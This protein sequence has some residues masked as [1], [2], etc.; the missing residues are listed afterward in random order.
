MKE[1]FPEKEIFAA[2]IPKLE[3]LEQNQVPHDDVN[4]LQF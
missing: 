4:H 2:R 3:S 1:W